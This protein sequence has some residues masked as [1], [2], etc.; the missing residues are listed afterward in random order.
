MCGGRG[1]AGRRGHFG[2][3]AKRALSGGRGGSCR[4]PAG[5]EKGICVWG[6][7]FPE[8]QGHPVCGSRGLCGLRLGQGMGV[9]G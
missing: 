4:S 9:G 7:A 1:L 6:G 3:E 5:G 8:G 2:V